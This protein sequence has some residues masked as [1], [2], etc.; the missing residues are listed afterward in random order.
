MLALKHV[1]ALSA[2]GGKHVLQV[3]RGMDVVKSQ[4]ESLR[5]R[6]AWS[7]GCFVDLQRPVRLRVRESKTETMLARGASIFLA[8]YLLLAVL[9]SAQTTFRHMQFGVAGGKAVINSHRLIAL[10]LPDKMVRGEARGSFQ[11]PLG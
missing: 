8:R 9:Y 2:D 6:P 4:A 1:N 7:K 10:P 3:L 5:R 11:A